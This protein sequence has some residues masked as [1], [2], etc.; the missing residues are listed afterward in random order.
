MIKPTADDSR[1]SREHVSWLSRK[2]KLRCTRITYTRF[3]VRTI[4]SKSLCFRNFTASSVKWF[5]AWDTRNL[6]REVTTAM[7]INLYTCFISRMFL[8]CEHVSQTSR[9]SSVA[10]LRIKKKFLFNFYQITK[11]PHFCWLKSLSSNI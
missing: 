11:M 5:E 8:C 9:E 1:N 3:S 10:G 4:F 7:W 2:T 6:S